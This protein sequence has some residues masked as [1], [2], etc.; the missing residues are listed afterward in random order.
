MYK[1]TPKE[2]ADAVKAI[3][4]GS[5]N[6]PDVYINRRCVVDYCPIYKRLEIVVKVNGKEQSVTVGAAKELITML[7]AAVKYAELV[8]E[9][10]KPDSNE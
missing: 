8:K 3:K 9:E 10:L 5:H 6:Y 4:P 2:F 1:L 7:K